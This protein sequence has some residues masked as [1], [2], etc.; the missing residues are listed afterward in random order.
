[1]RARLNEVKLCLLWRPFSASISISLSRRSSQL[2]SFDPSTH[3]L[4][5]FRM[6][7]ESAGLESGTDESTMKMCE[8][9]VNF[10]LLAQLFLPRADHLKWKLSPGGQPSWKPQ[11]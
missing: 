3:S 4:P 11:G 8:T 10:V 9:C 5:A 2:E 7:P 6:K 1:M